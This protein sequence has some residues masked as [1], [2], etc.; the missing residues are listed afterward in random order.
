MGGQKEDYTSQRPR[1]IT[2]SKELGKIR[3]GKREVLPDQYHPTD[4][5]HPVKDLVQGAYYSV[6]SGSSTAEKTANVYTD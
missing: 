6:T 2:V 5:V 4:C 1:L 3:T